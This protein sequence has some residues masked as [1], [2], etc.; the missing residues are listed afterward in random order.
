[1]SLPQRTGFKH[2]LSL[3]VLFQMVLA[4]ANYCCWWKK[5]CTS[6]YWEYPIVHRI[7]YYNCNRCLA[8]FLNHQQYHWL[9]LATFWNIQRLPFFKCDLWTRKFEVWS[10]GFEAFFLDRFMIMRFTLDI[11]KVH[12]WSWTWKLK[13]GHGKGD[14]FWK[15]SFSA[16]M[17]TSKEACDI[18]FF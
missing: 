8:G 15:P 1:M 5:S 11:K 12:P 18:V 7:S 13:I 14:S 3:I 9:L 16:S 10:C 17:L 2:Q 4:S 6:L